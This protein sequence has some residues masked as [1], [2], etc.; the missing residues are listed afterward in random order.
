MTPFLKTMLA[1][2]CSC[3]LVCIKAQRKKSMLLIIKP[4]L[5]LCFTFISDISCVFNTVK[6]SFT[7]YEFKLFRFSEYCYS[8]WHLC[9]DIAFEAL[10]TMKLVCGYQRR[11]WRDGGTPPRGM[12]S[13]HG[14]HAAPVTPCR[15][16]GP[17]LGPP[18]P[19]ASGLWSIRGLSRVCLP[20]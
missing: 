18:W 8:F 12:A 2:V 3:L 4:S 17:P 13:S 1:R 14:L 20:N 11:D 6:T 19:L 7:I 15:R 10:C 5:C 16:Y 9:I